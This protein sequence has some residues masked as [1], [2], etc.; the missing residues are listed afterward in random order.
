MSKEE[1]QDM[2]DKV[3]GTAPIPEEKHSVHSFLHKIATS[4]DTTKTGYLKEEEIGLP[5]LSLRACKELEL[6]C[7]EVADMNYFADFFGKTGEIL[8][9]TSLSKEGFLAKLAVII[10][11]ETSNILKAPM[12]QNRGWFKKKQSSE[13]GLP[14]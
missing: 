1:A 14:S 3:Y 12:K 10:R 2:L 5:T 11:R 7:K 4:D 6:F 8:T 13:G 9:S